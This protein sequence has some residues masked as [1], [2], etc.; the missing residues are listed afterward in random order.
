MMLNFCTTI[1]L[2]LVTP[3][4]EMSAATI[5]VSGRAAKRDDF[6]FSFYGS[7]H[8]H[9]WRQFDRRVE[10]RDAIPLFLMSD[11]EISMAAI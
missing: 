6:P 5:E 4:H 10:P 1:L 2:S 8:K 9:L 7:N 11:R 3:H